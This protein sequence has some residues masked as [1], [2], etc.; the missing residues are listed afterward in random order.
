MWGAGAATESVWMFQPNLLFYYKRRRRHTRCSR[1][2][3]SDVCSSDLSQRCRPA[4]RR[5]PAGVSRPASA[6][7]AVH[8]SYRAIRHGS[9]GE[10]PPAVSR[11]RRI[12]RGPNRTAGRDCHARRAVFIGAGAARNVSAAGGAAERFVRSQVVRSLRP[13]FHA[14]DL[15]RPPTTRR[16]ATRRGATELWAAHREGFP[17]TPLAFA[18]PPAVAGGRGAA[19]GAPG[20][21]TL[22]G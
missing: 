16:S 11:Q 15:A 2:W 10:L 21:D 5:P 20:L 14:N 4:G 17:G 13:G 12:S 9:G 1:D 18:P 19:G 6:R 7:R 8:R 22:A 3:S